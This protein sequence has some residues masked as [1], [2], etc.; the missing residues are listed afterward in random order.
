MCNFRPV[1]EVHAYLAEFP[2]LADL[3]G[4]S[5]TVS[6]LATATDPS[7]KRTA[8]RLAFSA[9]MTASDEDVSASLSAVS[10]A[11]AAKSASASLSAA[12][13]LF[14]R[15]CAFYPGD[16]GCFSA[17]LLNFV[18]IKPGQAFFMAANEPHAYLQ[19]QCVEI[20][21]NSDNVVRAGLTPKFKDVPNLIDML[22]YNDGPPTIMDGER[23]DKCTTLYQP[24]AA[25]FQLHKVAVPAGDAHDVPP[26][27]GVALILCLGGS[28][29][30][31]LSDDADATRL[32]LSPGRLYYVPDGK[33]VTVQADAAAV[34][35]AV[36]PDLVFFKAGVNE[37]M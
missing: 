16:V 30:L 21:A 26:S 37:S 12:D 33:A 29:W 32:P 3:C 19:G 4:G 9:L 14:Q 28:G 11:V 13:A 27:K 8:L 7:D 23:V 18:Q 5:A 10:D 22:T 20:M 35:G 31:R 24:P 1:A 25:E 36:S 34:Q 2:P 15:L 6:A 17:Y